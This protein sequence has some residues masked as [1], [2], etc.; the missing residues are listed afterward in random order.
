VNLIFKNNRSHFK[1]LYSNLIQQPGW[2]S[3]EQFTDKIKHEVKRSYRTGSP[4]SYVRIDFS[5]IGDDKSESRD[6][7]YFH[8][9][10]EYTKLITIKTREIDSKCLNNR[11]EIGILLIN[12]HVDGAKIFTEKLLNILKNHF[13]LKNELQYMDMINLIKFSSYPLNFISGKIN[14][15]AKPVI[16]NNIEIQKDLTKSTDPFEIKS[17]LNFYV[18]WSVKAKSSGYLYLSTTYPVQQTYQDLKRTLYIFVKRIMDISGAIFGL[19][20]FLPLM[21]VIAIAIKISSTGP[22]LFKQK[23]LGLSGEEFTFLKFRTMKADSKDDIHRDYIKKLIGGY[24]EGTNLGTKDV[25]LYKISFDPRITRFGNILRKSSLDELPQLINVL[26]GDMSLVGPRPPIPYEIDHY[27]TWHYRR[28]FDVKPGITGL[29]QVYGR[30]ITTF[31]EMV[32]LDLQY[33]KNQSIGLDI[34]LIFKTIA[35]VFNTRGAM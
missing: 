18:D 19:F 12:T 2:H 16:I 24:N 1:K 8:F 21:M 6:S 17:N 34:K 11:Y 13:K 33:V 23:R 29:W 3:L 4:L 5:A 20:L 35:A 28:I 14:I 31:N 10:N 30:S 32:R 27:K 15:E 25:P 22:I 9:L 7:N 26:K